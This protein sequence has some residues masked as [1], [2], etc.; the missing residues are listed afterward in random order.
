MNTKKKLL[1]HSCCAPCSSGVL[2]D[3]MQ[4][5]DVTVFFYNPNINTEEEYSLRATHQQKLC[6]ILNIPC[7]IEK[8]SPDIFLNSVKGH[9]KDKEGGARCL[10]CFQ[11]RLD[12]TAKY[13]KTNGYDIFTT[14]LSVSPYKNAQL[15][16]E[17]GNSI[18]Q[19]HNIEYLEA[20]FKKKNGYLKSVNNSKK[21]ELYRQKFCGC[22][23]SFNE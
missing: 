11:L 5:F 16:N 2:E 14:T 18:S 17:I 3:L 20:N 12:E 22:E 1:L 13:A 8:Y 19:K 15:L 10:K 7:I 21:Y 9:E 6:D 4:N 23:F